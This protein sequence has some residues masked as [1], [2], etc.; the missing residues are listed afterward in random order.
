ME[1]IQS[2]V[3]QR[4]EKLDIFLLYADVQGASFGADGAVTYS[5]FCEIGYGDFEFAA[6]AVAGSFVCRHDGALHGVRS[7]VCTIM[8]E[9]VLSEGGGRGLAGKARPRAS[10]SA[11]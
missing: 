8:Q 2:Q 10:A 6:A 1:L 3:I 11:S 7:K 5:H 4:C 9:K